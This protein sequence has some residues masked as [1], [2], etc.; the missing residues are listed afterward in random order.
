MTPLLHH[1]GSLD[2]DAVRSHLIAEFRSVL[3][4]QD[5]IEAHLQNEDREM[6]SDW[7]EMAQLV[8]NDEVLEALEESGRERLNSL[9]MAMQRLEQG[10][11]SECSACA[12]EI[13]PGR[14]AAVPTTTLCIDCA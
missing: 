8:E 6:P 7:S 3:H 11:Y 9:R 4:R 2:L 1:D 10:K 12:E 14:L 5:K 13:R